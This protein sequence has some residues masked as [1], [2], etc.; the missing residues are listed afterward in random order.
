MAKTK[1]C[2]PPP[3]NYQSLTVTCPQ[4]IQTCECRISVTMVVWRRMTGVKSTCKK[5]ACLS[6]YCVHTRAR[7]SAWVCMSDGVPEWVDGLVWASAREALCFH[8]RGLRKT[9]HETVHSAEVLNL[10]LLISLSLSHKSSCRER[11]RQLFA[12]IFLP[13]IQPSSQ[14]LLLLTVLFE[15]FQQGNV[16]TAFQAQAFCGYVSDLDQAFRCIDTQ[17]GS[18]RHALE[19]KYQHHSSS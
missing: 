14:H 8:P 9:A 3:D 18:T 7:V 6:V 15:Q 2:P 11:G 4:T 1:R 10:F 17:T 13:H 19:A 5:P 16:S 12:H